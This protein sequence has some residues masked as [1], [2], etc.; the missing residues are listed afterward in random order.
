LVHIEKFNKDAI[1]SCVYYNGAKKEHFVKRFEIATTSFNQRYCFISEERGSKL[2]VVTTDDD[3]IID[4]RITKGKGK[5]KT[6][7]EETVNINEF[8]DVKGWKTLG[9]RL[10]KHKVSSIKLV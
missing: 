7:E 5:S 10:S 8:I 4:F 1:I 6:V 2:N 3:P 9:N